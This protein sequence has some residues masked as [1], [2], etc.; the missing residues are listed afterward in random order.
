MKHCIIKWLDAA[1]LNDGG[2]HAP[3]Q[4]I[5]DLTCS[6]IQSSGWIIYEDETSVIIA[7]SIG[8]DGHD[9]SGETVIPRGCIVGREEL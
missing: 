5:K 7:G 8:A 9:V 2:W 6:V 3:E 4:V 1:S